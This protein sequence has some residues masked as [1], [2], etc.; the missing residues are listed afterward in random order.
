MGVDIS[1][2]YDRK[3]GR[4]R[5]VTKD[6]YVLLLV[7]LYQFLARRAKGGQKFNKM[8][9]R[10]LITTNTQRQPVSLKTIARLTNTPTM[11][12]EER[13]K[14]IVVAVATVTD[15]V[16]LFNVPKL[17]V[18]ALRFT[19]SARARILK[20]GGKC[21]TLDQLALVAPT[22]ANTMFLRGPTKCRKVYQ[23]F[24]PPPGSK[25]SKTKPYILSKAR[26]GKREIG[27]RPKK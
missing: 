5:A 8:V 15:D 3:S 11:P 25:G 14:K 23:H 2:K 18:A 13:E 12:A 27:K 22:G 7:K 17:T 4:T 24:G 16:R 6:P 10:R 19:S 21:L 26:K 9:L 20:A 1:H